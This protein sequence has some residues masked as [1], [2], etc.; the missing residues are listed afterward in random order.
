MDVFQRFFTTTGKVDPYGHPEIIHLDA[1]F[2]G[3]ENCKMVPY[4]VIAH[5]YSARIQKISAGRPIC[6]YSNTD[7]QN[8]IDILYDSRMFPIHYK[9]KEKKIL[10]LPSNQILSKSYIKI[11]SENIEQL[12]I[13][14]ENIEFETIEIIH[15]SIE[16]E[17]IHSMNDNVKDID[18]GNITYPFKKNR[19]YFIGWYR[20]N[21]GTAVQY[22][23]IEANLIGKCVRYVEVF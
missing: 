6:I 19:L 11:D 21:N 18:N 15:V 14:G 16:V 22:D 1:L 8:N 7:F 2:A 4:I 5:F 23:N 10:K 17:Y 12:K 20:L 13:T 3:R 9:I